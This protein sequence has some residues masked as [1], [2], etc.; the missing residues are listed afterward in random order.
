MQLET[1]S[2]YYHENAD[3]HAHAHTT[4]RASLRVTGNA[5]TRTTLLP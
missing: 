5:G 2:N 3:T 1:V 4:T